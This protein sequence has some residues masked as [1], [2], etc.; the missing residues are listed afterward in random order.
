MDRARAC[1][2]EIVAMHQSG[3]DANGAELLGRVVDLFLV[4]AGNQTTQDRKTFGEVMERMAYTTDSLSRSN[5]AERLATV[6]LAPVDLMRRLA[7]DEIFIARPIL[8][9]SPSLREGDLVS[10]TRV[11]EQEH[12]KATAHRKVLTQPVTDIIVKRGGLGVLQVI[13]S[14]TGAE[15][16][17]EGLDYLTRA[18]ETHTDL[19]QAINL[20]RKL[21]PRAIAKLKRLADV[22]FWQQMAETMLMTSEEFEKNSASMSKK[23]NSASKGQTSEPKEIEPDKPQNDENFRPV[24]QVSEGVLVAHARAGEVDKTVESFASVTQ[25]DATMVEHCLFQ[26]HISALMVLCKAHNLA[27]GTFT[28]L[29]QIRETV[30]G[31]PTEDMVGMMRRYESMTAETAKRI[32][33]FSE[34]RPMPN[35]NEQEQASA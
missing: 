9:Y 23:A 6:E 14:N 11:A 26:A 18:A 17:P 21:G 16:S 10:I 34:K 8:Q 30:T 3:P 20:R 29:L 25:L 32:I 15:F 1:L 12:L 2:E 31:D 24:E 27:P 22:N 7:R 33:N 5:L 35:N 19:Q 4:T 13:I 28:T